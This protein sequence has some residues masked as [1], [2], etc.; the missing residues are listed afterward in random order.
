MA[1]SPSNLLV[2]CAA[3]YYP[4]GPEAIAHKIYIVTLFSPVTF[5]APKAVISVVIVYHAALPWLL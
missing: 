4:K 2:L 5:F 1:D 3:P